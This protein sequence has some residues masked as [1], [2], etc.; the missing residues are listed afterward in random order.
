MLRC[1]TPFLGSMSA[2]FDNRLTHR[3]PI[4]LSLPLIP[5]C[6]LPAGLQREDLAILAERHTTSKLRAFED[7]EGIA[8]L[9]FRCGGGASGLRAK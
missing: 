4:G 5:P 2:R 6:P 1:P 9:G 3:P 8:T 7:L